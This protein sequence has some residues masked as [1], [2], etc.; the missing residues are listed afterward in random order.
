[1]VVATNYNLPSLNYFWVKLKTSSLINS[2]YNGNE[3]YVV[4]KLKGVTM[5]ES[6]SSFFASR[7][8]DETINYERAHNG[9]I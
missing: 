6:V 1:L 3:K 4:A 2:K 5:T 9:T 8:R 7:D